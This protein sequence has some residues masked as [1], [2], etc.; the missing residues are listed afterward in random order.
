MTDPKKDENAPEK[1]LPVKKETVKDLTVQPE[2]E[3]DVVGGGGGSPSRP[4]TP[5]NYT[6][7]AC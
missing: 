3:D 1:N 4:R 7:A 6:C 2:K 5:A